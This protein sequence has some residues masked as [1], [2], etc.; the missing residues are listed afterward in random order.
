MIIDVLAE[1][2]GRYQRKT[3]QRYWPLDHKV[4]C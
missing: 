1:N 4:Q 3:E 2:R